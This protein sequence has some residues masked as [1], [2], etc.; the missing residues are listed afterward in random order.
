[1]S[2][3]FAENS[4]AKAPQQKIMSSANGRYVFSQV[5]EFA[6]HQYMLDTQTG[7]LWQIVSDEHEQLKLS[8]IP[9]I[10]VLLGDDA[11][12]PDSPSDVEAHRKFTRNSTL[13]KLKQ[14]ATT[15]DK[16]N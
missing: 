1:V 6:R 15:E 13:Q 4:G 16:S 8:P 2:F 11:Y 12:I 7:R 10:Q 14:D 9:Y 3:A 5:S